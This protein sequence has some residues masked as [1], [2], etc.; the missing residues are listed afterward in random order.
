M[1][2]K[3][4]YRNEDW[5]P[6]IETRFFE[7]LRRARDKPQYL[8]IQACHLAERHPDVAL[9]L[10]EKY[11]ALGDH[12]DIA[13]AFHDQARA[14][15]ALGDKEKGLESLK[16]ALARERAY[17]NVI[18]QSWSDFALF[19]AIE[20]LDKL[21]EDALDVLQRY[22]RCVTFP[23]DEFHWHGA[24]ALISDA[25]GDKETAAISSAQALRAADA[26]HSGFPRHPKV[27]LVGEQDAKLKMQLA[28]LEVR[29]KLE[30]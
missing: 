27:G 5:N 18:T 26:T 30:T 3:D 7:K 9:T 24:L 20:R 16:K 8:R 1:C 4:W 19:V 13:Q 11:F 28:A 10:L 6:E 2:A 17:P 22:R 14:L 12:W 15:F 21:F 29:L 25:I 23:K